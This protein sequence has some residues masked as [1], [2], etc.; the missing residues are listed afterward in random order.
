MEEKRS[1]KQDISNNKGLYARIYGRVQGVGFRYS[2]IMQGR[3]LFLCG[4][5][6]NMDDGS[7]EVVAEGDVEHLRRLLSWLKKGPTGSR[8][9]RVDSH[10][11]PYSGTYRTFGVEY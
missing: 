1:K 8:V 6:R 2:T 9:D 5:A 3:G 10:P 4:Y 11:I 7:V